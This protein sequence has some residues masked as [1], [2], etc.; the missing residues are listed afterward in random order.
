MLLR[1]G[2]QYKRRY[3]DKD[4]IPPNAAM[5]RG[6]CGHE[7]LGL[8]YT[9]KVESG[10]DLP[11]EEVESAFS[12]AWD[13][14]SYQIDWRTDELQGKPKKVVSGLFKDSGV[15]L[16]KVFH[17]ELS[18]KIH[19]VHVEK[20]FRVNFEGGYPDLLGYMD[21]ID[22][23]DEIGEK[24]FV[25][26]SP[27]YND[28][29]T[30]EQLTTYDLGFRSMFGR[31]PAKLKK[32]WAVALKKPKTVEQECGPRSDAHIQ[33]FLRRLER[34][35]ISIDKEIFLPAAPGHWCCSPK[36]CGYWETCK[37]RNG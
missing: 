16:V 15:G 10:I 36:W 30:D 28:V 32:Q 19:P 25:S 4:I 29:T 8:N 11:V 34:A 1:C 23:G 22:Q 5:T 13:S 9:Q 33:R 20:E 7:A 31:K 26:K 21:R 24:K 6:K 27:M 12:E 37:V 17:V 18:P 14:Y 3:L 35:S 2:E